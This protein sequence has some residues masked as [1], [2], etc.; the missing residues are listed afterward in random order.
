MKQSD[1]WNNFLVKNLNPLN[2]FGADSRKDYLEAEESSSISDEEE[3][4]LKE[5]AEDGV[6]EQDYILHEG[7]RTP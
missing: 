1:D 2:L 3:S 7:V 6:L 4:I 5:V